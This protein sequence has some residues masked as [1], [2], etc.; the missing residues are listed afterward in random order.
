M[1]QAIQKGILRTLLVALWVGTCGRAQV[2]G[3]SSSTNN[4]FNETKKSVKIVHNPSKWADENDEKK[5]WVENHPNGKLNNKLQATFVYADTIYMKKG[6]SITLTLPDILPEKK[7]EKTQMH[8]N[9][10]TYQRWYNY[11]TDGTFATKKEGRPHLLT[12]T[13]NNSSYVNQQARQ[14]YLLQNGYLGSPF[15]GKGNG[16]NNVE[17]T[18]FEMDFYYPTDEEYKKWDLNGQSINNNNLYLVAVD[19]SNYTD[20]SVNSNLNGLSEFTEPTLSHRVIFTIFGVDDNQTDPSEY[21]KTMSSET[22]QG[23]NADNLDTKKYWEEYDITYPLYHFSGNTHE[24]VALTKAANAYAVPNGA[25]NDETPLTVTLINGTDSK[26]SLAENDESKTTTTVSGSSRIFHLYYYGEK[27]MGSSTSWIRSAGKDGCTATLLVTKTV[28][29]KTYNLARYNLTFE[30][31]TIQLTQSQ[32]KI[33]DEKQLPNTGI[34]WSGW[35]ELGFRT[36]KYLDEHYELQNRISFDTPGDTKTYIDKPS[37]SWENSSYGFFDG[38]DGRVS[39]D[40]RPQWGYFAI[41]N[42]YVENSRAPSGDIANYGRDENTHH[43]YI[44]ASDHPGV[45][46]RLPFVADLCPGSE[47]LVSAMVLSV[48]TGASNDGAMLFTVMGVDANGGYTPIHRYQTGQIYS[49]ISTQNLPGADREWKQV[50]FSFI[51]HNLGYKSYVLQIE[52]NSASTAGGDMCLDEIRVYSSRPRVD[53]NTLRP[54]CDPQSDR[55]VQLFFPWGSLVNNETEGTEGIHDLALCVIDSLTYRKARIEGKE[56]VEALEESWVDLYPNNNGKKI[57]KLTYNKEF[58]SNDVYDKDNSNAIEGTD[59][60]ISLHRMESPQKGMAINLR[61]KFVANRGYKILVT[62]SGGVG[63]ISANSFPDPDN[64]ECNIIGEFALESQNQIEL[65]AELY[66][67][68]DLCE[69]QT[70]NFKVRMRAYNDKTGAFIGQVGDEDVVFYDWFLGPEEEFLKENSNYGNV[71]LK[72]AL[73]KLRAEYPTVDNKMEEV[74]ATG[75][76]TD[77]MLKLIKSYLMNS[78]GNGQTKEGPKLILYQFSMDLP[79]SNPLNL[80]VVPIKDDKIDSKFPSGSLCWNYFPRTIVPV[81]KAPSVFVGFG[82]VKYPEYY[83]QV[84]RLGLKQIKA[85]DNQPQRIKIPLRQTKPITGN[86]TML[87]ATDGKEGR[88]DNHLYLI[89]T[90]DPAYRKLFDGTSNDEYSYP[91]GTVEQLEASQEKDKNYESYMYISFDLKGKL[92]QGERSDFRFTPHE[93]FHYVVAFH[94]MEK[95]QDTQFCSGR[96]VLWLKVVPEYMRWTGNGQAETLKGDWSNRGN[97]ARASRNEMNLN[98]ATD[99]EYETYNSSTNGYAPMD[100]TNIILPRGKAISLLEPEYDDNLLIDP[101]SEHKILKLRSDAS[102]NGYRDMEF[103]LAVRTAPGSHQDYQYDCR[104]YYIHEVNQVHFEPSAEM[105]HAERLNYEKV[106]VDYELEKGR[107]YTL[108]SPF[109]EGTMYAGDW[110]TD[111]N[112]AREGEIYF[113]DT[114]KSG[115]FPVFNEN[116][117]SRINPTVYQRNRSMDNTIYLDGEDKQQTAF[118]SGQW[119]SLY[120]DVTVSYDTTQWVEANMTKNSWFGFSVKVLDFTNNEGNRALFRFPKA[121]KNFTYYTYNKDG[122][123]VS[124]GKSVGVSRAEATKLKVGEVAEVDKKTIDLRGSGFARYHLIS[125]PF[126]AHLDMIKFFKENNAGLESKYWLVTADNQD[127][128]I[129]NAKEEGWTLVEGTSAK[130][131][132]LQSFFVKARGDYL[133]TTVTFTSD[134]QTLGETVLT[135]AEE[136]PFTRAIPQIRITA[137]EGGRESHAVIVYDGEALSSFVDSEDAELFLDSNLDQVPMVYT[138]AGTQAVSINRTSDMSDLPLGIFS[139]SKGKLSLTFEGL[140]NFAEVSL[141]DARDRQ[142]RPLHEGSMVVVDSDSH[143]RYFLRVGEATANE[144]LEDVDGGIR[145]F[146]AARGKVVVTSSSVPLRAVSLFG[147]DGKPVRLLTNLSSMSEVIELPE[148]LY[149]IH[150]RTDR[151]EKSEKVII[152]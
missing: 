82:D 95:D 9:A 132:P 85:T 24:L 101:K 116:A 43:M 140:D 87:I 75:S 76:F 142:E 113:Y 133:A 16:W 130:I 35:K 21:E 57:C 98:N 17:R 54:I 40:N 71:S 39:V 90:N 45:I 137:T 114:F 67:N 27:D 69:N 100:F 108:A 30:K 112:T 44:D 52:N 121:D 18:I 110:Y 12:R 42:S 20:G 51:N 146:S 91:I 36:P 127:V 94:F 22:F 149:V 86:G 13:P 32:L 6:K 96:E 119:S 83:K 33:L 152:Y 138:V 73:E 145:I 65:N 38:T 84:V 29:S 135:K 131:A 124:T 3:Q 78:S 129:E 48:A 136:N 139:R 106:W 56:H 107:W 5:E 144:P 120:N 147:I 89:D 66:G 104:T 80:V 50:F 26:I 47:I 58:S 70:Y 102:T 23:G 55:R 28:N 81:G 8:I 143:G 37:G 14:P 134:M 118:I 122:T 99:V 126:M 88:P 92:L 79:I 61:G 7:G 150:A 60:K 49:R 72:V 93:G 115:L 11:Y 1:K 105:L 10:T 97:W 63:D 15:T 41:T 141:Y 77:D 62:Q 103:D 117:N 74:K 68:A 111:R 4:S 59:G 25:D 125:N 109:L 31:S 64:S 19:V 151:S 46:A 53:A 148:G 128:A 34:D 2:W 123:L